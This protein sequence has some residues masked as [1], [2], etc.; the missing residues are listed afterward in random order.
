[1]GLLKI[2]RYFTSYRSAQVAANATAAVLGRVVIPFAHRLHRVDYSLEVAGSTGT[3]TAV[4][5]QTAA[6]DVTEAVDLATGAAVKTGSLSV[7]SALGIVRP[8]GTVYTM[9]AT[10]S[11]TNSTIDSA[12][13]T[14]TVEPVMP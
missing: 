3:V 13:F 2:A 9:L 4:S 12:A 10:T 6:A 1:M 11:A 14:V 5:L 8:A 7:V